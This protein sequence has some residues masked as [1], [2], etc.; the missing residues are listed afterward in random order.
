PRRC[1][2]R[3]YRCSRSRWSS[4]SADAGGASCEPSRSRYPNRNRVGRPVPW[5]FPGVRLLHRPS[6]LGPLCLPRTTS[7]SAH[8]AK[9][10][11]EQRAML[12][13]FLPSVGIE[14]FGAD[15]ELRKPAKVL[16]VGAR[17]VVLPAGLG[18]QEI[19][20]AGTRLDGID[21]R[22]DGVLVIGRDED[23]RRHRPV[24]LAGPLDEL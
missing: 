6:S 17:H 22:L 10:T 18:A 23:D 11:S 1:E 5:P 20:A 8:S 15:P 14:A 7:Q 19:F 16:S 21:E 3:R 13:S 4:L 9:S 2:R 12:A 24:L